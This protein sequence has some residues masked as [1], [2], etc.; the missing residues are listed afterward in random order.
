[1]KQ[2]DTKVMTVEELASLK[3]R[4]EVNPHTVVDSAVVQRLIETVLVCWA[5][6]GE[7][8]NVPTPVHEA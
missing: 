2:P 5:T 8:G 7:N 3:A 4:L 1:M 6:G